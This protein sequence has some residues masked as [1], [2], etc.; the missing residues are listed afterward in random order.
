VR[1]R[2]DA[3]GEVLVAGGA[4]EGAGEGADVVVG[5]PAMNAITS[6]SMSP[7]GQVRRT[8]TC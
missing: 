8:S 1:R 6:M 5:K 7:F 2:R 4:D 3:S